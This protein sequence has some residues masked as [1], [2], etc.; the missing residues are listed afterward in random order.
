VAVAYKK[1]GT[2]VNYTRGCIVRVLLLYMAYLS[3]TCG[4]CPILSSLSLDRGIS[5]EPAKVSGRE[6]HHDLRCMV[7]WGMQCACP[8][9]LSFAVP[10]P[11]AR[12]SWIMTRGG[13]EMTNGGAIT[14]N[15]EHEPV[16]MHACIASGEI[17]EHATNQWMPSFVSARTE[18]G[19]QW[20]SLPITAL[21]R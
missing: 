10:T 17:F 2:A 7:A 11:P 12:C 21:R 15:A 18:G 20:T 8:P 3:E 13:R 5:G 9:T 6:P 1:G 14:E 19:F 4:R 16:P